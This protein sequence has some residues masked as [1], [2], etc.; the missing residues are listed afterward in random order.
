MSFGTGHHETTHLMLNAVLELDVKGKS[1]LDMGCGTGVLAILASKRGAASAIAIDYDAWAYENTIE[2]IE[3]NHVANVQALHGG[4]EIIPDTKFD[5]ILANINRNI[6]LD[7]MESYRAH[8]QPNG[9]LLI[10]GI[11]QEDEPV[12]AQCAS[13]SKFTFSKVRRRKQWS[14]MIFHQN[15]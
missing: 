9:I 5:I 14:M 1:I 13:E 10:S 11:L 7:Q 15:G 6:L 3:R 12:L 8:I 4:K 2:N